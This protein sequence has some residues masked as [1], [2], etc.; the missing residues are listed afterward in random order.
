MVFPRGQRGPFSKL[1]LQRPSFWRKSESKFSGYSHCPVW[2]QIKTG[3]D[4][5]RNRIFSKHQSGRSFKEL[6]LSWRK[7]F[8]IMPRFWDINSFLK[9]VQWLRI[10]CT[11]QF[12]DGLQNCFKNPKLVQK[13]FQRQFLVL[14]MF[15]KTF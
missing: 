5:D 8:K 12:K 14:K 7:Y 9:T 6:K 13:L 15:Y 3:I 4:W 2:I 10:S 1:R 11:V